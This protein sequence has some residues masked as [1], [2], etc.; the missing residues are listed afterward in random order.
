[1]PFSFKILKTAQ[2]FV[3]RKLIEA[4]CI[5]EFS[6]DINRDQGW[7]SLAEKLY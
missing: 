5:R 1:M 6:P 2:S 3:E 7:H 4:T